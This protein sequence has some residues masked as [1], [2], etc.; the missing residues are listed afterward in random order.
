MFYSPLRY[1]GG[2]GKLTSFIAMMIETH[3]HKGGTYIEPFAGGAAV[4]IELLERGVVS[5]IVI[6]DF[7][8]GIY[9]FWRA[10]LTE[11]NRFINEIENIPINMDEWYK[12]RNICMNKKSKYSFELGFATFYMNRTNRSGIIKGGVIGGKSQNGTW[13][14][15]ARFNKKELIERIRKISKNKCHIHLYNK[16]VDSFIINYIPKY[17]SNVFVYFDPPYFRKGC[18]LYMNFFDYKDHA[19][20]EHLISN[21]VNCD[22][23]ITYDNEPEI[24]KIYEKS[25]IKPFELN[26]SVANKRKAQ[27]LLILKNESMLPSLVPIHNGSVCINTK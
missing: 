14:L 22:W 27:E 6:N 7:D 17:N 2:K 16:N 3:G 15:N 19:R 5:E 10:I 25:Y 4:A 9:S 8:K 11:T 26:Y 12:Q 24:I 23:M 13:R 18:Q 1:P 21:K 20:I